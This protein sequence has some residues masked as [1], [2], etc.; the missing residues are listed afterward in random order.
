[1]S[2]RL[3]QLGTLAAGMVLGA[4][5]MFVGLAQ[6]DRIAPSRPDVL[7]A[8]GQ[9][10]DVEH[11]AV[12]LQ[13]EKGDIAAAIE[14]LEALRSG[15]WPSPA[16]A[17]GAAVALKHDA[18]GRLVRLR[19]DHPEV[20]PVPTDALLKMVDEGLG[21]DEVDANPFTARLWALRG[22]LYETEGL[23]DEALEAYEKAL[24]I[25]ATLLERELGGAP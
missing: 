22:E 10:L 4:A 15:P 14:S 17:T 12:D 6:A 9:R 16:D 18:Y 23:D 5:G 25:N 21:E 8:L 1:M 20:D 19:L 11:R 3:G 7:V 24:E 2:R 13:L